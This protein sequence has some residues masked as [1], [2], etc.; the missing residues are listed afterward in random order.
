[1]EEA[2]RF[3]RKVF[4]DTE[5]VALILEKSNLTVIPAHTRVIETGKYVREVPLVI[6]GRIKVMHPYDVDKEIML[7]YIEPGESC[8]LSIGAG[9]TGQKSIIYADTETETKLLSIPVDALPDLIFRFPQMTTFIL[10]HIHKRFTDLFSYIDSIVFQKMDTR[11]LEHLKR[12]MVYPESS[13][14][15]TTHQELANELGTAREVISRLLKQLE[16][17]GKVVLHRSEIKIIDK[18]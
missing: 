11:L 14:L 7:C 3:L 2:H 13:V 1:M 10:S 16:Q 9:V 4:S 8:A 5:L 12:K 6:K 18:L 17:S 15:H